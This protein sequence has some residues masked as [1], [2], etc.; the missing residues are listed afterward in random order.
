MDNFEYGSWTYVYYRYLSTFHTR[1]RDWTD[2]FEFQSYTNTEA[3]V[4]AYTKA[5]SEGK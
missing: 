4:I 1:P 3:K 2:L 5:L